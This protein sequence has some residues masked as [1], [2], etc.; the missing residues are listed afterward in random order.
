MADGVKPFRVRDAYGETQDVA[1]ITWLGSTEPTAFQTVSIDLPFEG[2]TTSQLL[3]FAKWLPQAVAE[4]EK[5]NKKA[6]RLRRKLEDE[7]YDD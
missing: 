7:G 2:L 3:R 1:E 6:R 5:H 4:V